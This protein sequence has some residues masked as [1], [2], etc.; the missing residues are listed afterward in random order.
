[1]PLLELWKDLNLFYWILTAGLEN[2]KERR[3]KCL[4]L[5]FLPKAFTPTLTCFLG[6]MEDSGVS[7][8]SDK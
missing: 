6:D 8:H 4:K 3:Y 5:W 7:C 2:R 1:M